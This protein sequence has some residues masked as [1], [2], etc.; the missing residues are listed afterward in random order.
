MRFSFLITLILF[1]LNGCAPGSFSVDD[2][3][4]KFSIPF[5]IPGS[6]KQEPRETKILQELE[7]SNGEAPQAN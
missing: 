1:L 7:I 5:D 3:I 4:A 6:Q 2:G